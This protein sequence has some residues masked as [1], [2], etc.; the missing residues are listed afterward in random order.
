[1]PLIGLHQI[2]EI[3]K[4]AEDMDNLKKQIGN[5]G[6]GH[7]YT[8]D[9]FPIKNPTP[10][11]QFKLSHVPDENPVSLEINHVVYRPNDIKVEGDT[12]TWMLT[13]DRGGF[14]ITPDITDVVYVEYF[15]NAVR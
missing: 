8:V 11:T 1:M 5:S 13:G 7:I 4:F 10:V 9:E 14:D 15:Y 6:S 2:N 12:V 3:G